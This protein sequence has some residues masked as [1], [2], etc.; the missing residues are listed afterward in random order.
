MLYVVLREAQD[1]DIDTAI[2]ECILLVVI[3]YRYA[4]WRPADWGVGPPRGYTLVKCSVPV[5]G[6]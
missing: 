2:T 4:R 1:R 5:R 6:P 3:T